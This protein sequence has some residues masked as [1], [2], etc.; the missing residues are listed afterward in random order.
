MN[1]DLAKLEIR[2]REAIAQSAF[3]ENGVLEF[4][5]KDEWS[6]VRR[7]V[8]TNLNATDTILD[9]LSKDEDSCVRVSVAKNPTTSGKILDFLSKVLLVQGEGDFGIKYF[10]AHNPN[11]PEEVRENLKEILPQNTWAQT[12]SIEMLRDYYDIEDDWY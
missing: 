7:S 9:S 12:P 8:A 11:T 2:V 4:L 6:S 1:I 3:V 10:V 5:S